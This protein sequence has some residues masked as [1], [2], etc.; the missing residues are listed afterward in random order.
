MGIPTANLDVAVKFSTEGLL[1]PGVYFGKCLLKRSTDEIV[2]EYDC[3]YNIGFCPYYGN[4]KPTI[5]THIF[6]TFTETFYGAE[7]TARI[8]GFIRPERKFLNFGEILPHVAS[9][10]LPEELII[11]IQLDCDSVYQERATWPHRRP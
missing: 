1:I 7:L 5:E 6:H 4:Q 8:H 3:I 9:V 11:T 2:D 10:C